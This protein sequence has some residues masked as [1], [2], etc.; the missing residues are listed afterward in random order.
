M[1]LLTD[2][3]YKI[4]LFLLVATAVT[5]FIIGRKSIAV[6]QTIATDNIVK[7][8]KGHKQTKTVTIKDKAGREKTTTTITE[9][10]SSSETE[11]KKLLTTIAQGYKYNASALMTLGINKIPQYGFQI[12]REFIG[13]I[14]VGAFGLEGGTYGLSVGINF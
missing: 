1:G 8:D 6:S 13:P 10:T 9:D 7:N 4:A 3:R 12:S 14:T 2:V 5:F 11:S